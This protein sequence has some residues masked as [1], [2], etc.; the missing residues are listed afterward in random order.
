MDFDQKLAFLH[1]PWAAESGKLIGTLDGDW[2][3]AAAEFSF[4]RTFQRLCML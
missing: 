3:E 1:S 2:E 4:Y